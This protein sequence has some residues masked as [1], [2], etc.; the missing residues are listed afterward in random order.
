MSISSTAARRLTALIAVLR[1]YVLIIGLLCIIVLTVPD[2]PFSKLRW[3]ETVL[4]LCLTFYIGEWALRAFAVRERSESGRKLSAIVNLTDALIIL[5]VPAALLFGIAPAT[6]WLLAGLWLIKVPAAASG[7]SLLRRVFVLE[8][9]PLASVVVVFL[10][11]LFISAVV[12]HLVERDAQPAAFGTLPQALYWAVTTLSTT[13][14]GDVVPIT[15]LGRLVAGIV[16]ISGLAVFGLWTGILANG[17]AAETRRR[18]FTRTWEFVARVPFFKPLGPAAIIEIARMLRPQQVAERTVIIRKGRHGDSMYF[19]ASGQVEIAGTNPKVLLGEGA[20]FGELALLGDGIRTATV[21]A[22]TP[23][24]LLVLELSDYRIFAAQ[25]P[26]LASSVEAEGAR[27]LAEV[28]ASRAAA[29]D[30]THTQEVPSG[31]ESAG[32]DP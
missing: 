7:F 20:F 10:F 16:M 5:P 1:P 24:S 30:A 15:H 26:D 11:V 3:T 4:W 8:A 25:H 21:I 2:L 28:R 14:Y 19:I 18:D 31:A 6:A 13:G 9:K 23:T 32:T 29:I 22:T 27:R 17:F 12:M